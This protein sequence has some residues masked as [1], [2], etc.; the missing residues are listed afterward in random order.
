[1]CSNE[2]LFREYDFATT[3]QG[4]GHTESEFEYIG[5]DFPIVAF[6]SG[7]IETIKNIQ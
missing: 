6:P 1:M 2:S 5:T 3:D 4:Q 7:K